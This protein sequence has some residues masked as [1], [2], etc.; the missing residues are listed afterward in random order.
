[1]NMRQLVNN[2]ETVLG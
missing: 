1:M 2:V